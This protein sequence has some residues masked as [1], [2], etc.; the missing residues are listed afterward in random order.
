MCDTHYC[1]LNV[2][3]RLK[4]KIHPYN[5]KED[6]HIES[7]NP[8]LEKEVVRRVEFS[9]FKDAD[10]TISR[11]IEFYNKDRLHS[12]VG[13]KA[14]REVYEEWKESILEKRLLLQSKFILIIAC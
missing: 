3:D 14:P 6:A 1:I 9:F 4:N 11:L 5:T 12:A 10:D 2:G 8:I 7:F 13:Y